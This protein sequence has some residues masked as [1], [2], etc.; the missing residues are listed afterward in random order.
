[1]QSDAIDLDLPKLNRENWLFL[2]SL[3]V[4]ASLPLGFL[5]VALI[6]IM[7]QQGTP[8]EQLSIVYSA[9]IFWALKFLWAPFIDRWRFGFLGHYR[10]WL[11]VIQILTIIALLTLSK[12]DVIQDFT[13]IMIVSMLI[14]FLSATLDAVANAQAFRLLPGEDRGFGNS[15][16]ASGRLIGNLFGGGIILM[17]YPTFGWEGSVYLL[18]LGITLSLVLVLRFKE[19]DFEYHHPSVGESIKRYVSF[20][21]RS[22]GL[23]WLLC[24]ATY[25]LG[26]SLAWPLITPM[27]VD[28]QWQLNEIGF[29]VNVIG[30][31]LGIVG[32]MLAG[33]LI[34]QYGRRFGVILTLIMQIP[35]A[36]LLILITQGYTDYL[37]VA[38]IVSTLM[39]GYSPVMSVT[40]TLMMD[41]AS[42]RHP[43][44]DIALQYSL[45]NLF[46]IFASMLATAMAGYFGY[47]FVLMAA[48]ATVFV[49]LAVSYRYPFKEFKHE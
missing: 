33:W 36:L 40:F 44:T 31:I 4:S 19:D 29:V 25:P 12:L 35:T 45:F 43:A 37:S 39:F 27:L 9:G 32:A 42:D 2:G 8:L 26:I 3:Y 14:G 18:I 6:A 17:L 23:H 13:G 49:A 38:L 10:G 15:L 22:N 21:K 46:S 48:A 1:M 11:I 20:W 41:H 7:R 34:K 47:P 28:A 16:Q 24:L 5:F 30:S